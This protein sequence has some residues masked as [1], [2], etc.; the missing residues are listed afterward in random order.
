M[1]GRFPTLSIWGLPA[2]VFIGSIK[3]PFLDSGNPVIDRVETPLVFPHH[4][5]PNT[6]LDRLAD[7][8]DRAIDVDQLVLD[9]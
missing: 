9:A 4:V 3:H 6:L 1:V 5:A 8:G 7:I 2:P